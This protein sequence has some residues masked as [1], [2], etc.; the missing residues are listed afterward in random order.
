MKSLR[1]IA[2]V[3]TLAL[4]ACGTP[5]EPQGPVNTL[6]RGLPTAVETLDQHKARSTQAAEVL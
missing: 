3:A 2:F 6:E 5:D 1:L 4:A